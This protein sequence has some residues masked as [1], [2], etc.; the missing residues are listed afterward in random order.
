MSFDELS[1]FIYA[2][3]HSLSLRKEIRSCKSN[4]MIVSLANRYGYRISENDLI[5]NSLE[6]RID[7]WFNDSKIRPIKK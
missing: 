2:I 4:K 5:D 1:N 7:E 3:E 6:Q